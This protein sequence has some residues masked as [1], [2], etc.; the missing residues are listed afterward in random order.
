M[1]G[2][3]QVPCDSAPG[4]RPHSWWMEGLLTLILLILELTLVLGQNLRLSMVLMMNVYLPIFFRQTPKVIR[5]Q[6]DAAHLPLPQYDRHRKESSLHGRRKS[7]NRAA[8][9][10]FSTKSLVWKL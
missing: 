6:M 5:H 1:P 10:G 8:N 7:L 4:V 3:T 2:T 9:S